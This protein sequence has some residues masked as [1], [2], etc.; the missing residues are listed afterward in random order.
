MHYVD[1]DY[2]LSLTNDPIGIEF[3]TDGA[4]EEIYMENN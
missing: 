2:D 1:Y 4:F 3:D